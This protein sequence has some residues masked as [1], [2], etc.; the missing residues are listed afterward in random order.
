MKNNMI[1]EYIKSSII[2]F[3]TAFLMVMVSEPTLWSINT[4]QHGAY[5]GVIIAGC[6]AGV[7]ALIEYLISIKGNI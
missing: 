3:V 6:R 2:T 5:A 1:K 4:L 7:K